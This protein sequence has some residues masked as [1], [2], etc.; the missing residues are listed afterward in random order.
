MNVPRLS[1]ISSV[2]IFGIWNSGRVVIDFLSVA[3][4]CGLVR[5]YFEYSSTMSCSCTGVSISSRSGR[6]S[7]FA[8][9]AS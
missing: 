8:V 1:S 3:G 4:V 5:D 6:R 2:E 7:T 9:R